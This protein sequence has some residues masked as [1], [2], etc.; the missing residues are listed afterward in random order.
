MR[1]ITAAQQGV[2]NTGRQAEY[3]R[4]SV[5]DSG[6][7]FRD[8]TTYPGFNAVKSVKWSEQIDQPHATFDI[9]LFRELYSLSL[10]PYVQGSALNR[11][12]NPANAFAALLAV[13]RELKIEVAIVAMDTP[14]GGSDWF[15][16]FH[17]RIETL[18][19]AN[20]FD[21]QMTGTSLGGRLSKQ[22]IKT[23]RVYSYAATAGVAVACRIWEAGQSYVTTDYLI[24]ASRGSSDSGFNKFLKCHV[25]GTSGTTE[26][27]WTTGAAQADNTTS[28]DY[29]G[30]PTVAG[31]PVEQIMQNILND[32]QGTGDPSVT[33]FT[34]SSPGWNITQFIQQREF[35]LD[36]IVALATQI[37]WDV[38][39]KWRSGTSQFEL[40]FY[41]PTRSSPTVNQTFGPSDY[42]APTQ[43]KVDINSIRNSV[44]V[45]Y[46]DASD[47]WP[48]GTPKRKVVEVTD[49]G[50][51]TKYGEMWME[52][53]E[54]QTSQIDTGAEATAFANAALSDCKDPTAELDIPIVHGFPWV[55]LNDYYTF[56]ANGLQFDTDQSLAVTQYSHDF[57]DGKMKTSFQTRGLPTIGATTYLRMSVHPGLQGKFFPH[58][59]VHFN[60]PLTPAV[61]LSN[62]V[63]GQR[64]TL[65][66]SF[67]K[68]Q[69]AEEY[70]HHVYLS[71]GATLDNTTL[72]AITPSRVLDAADLITARTYYH[73][74]VPR[75]RNGN[76]LIRMQPSVES[77]I[78]PFRAL[79]SHIQDGIA[80]GRYPLNGGFETRQD[81]TLPPD[82]WTMTGGV[83]GTNADIMND[84]SGIS[85]SNYI[86][87]VRANAGG[88]TA[89][90][91]S[92]TI[93]IVGDQIIGGTS[94]HTQLYR[95]SLWC[96]CDAANAT[97]GICSIWAQGIDYTGAGSSGSK[98]NIDIN[99]NANSGRWQFFEAYF[100]F[101]ADANTRGLYIV[102]NGPTASA[103]G[104][105]NK[106][107]FD[108]LRL[109][110]VGTPWY[111]VN[112]TTQLTD[113]NEALP[114]F[115]NSYANYDA[116]NEPT[117]AFRR[118]QY[119]R[120]YARGLVAN[121]TTTFVNKIIFTLP[122]SF[123]PVRRWHWATT[124][125]GKFGQL[126]VATTGDVVLTIAD[127]ANPSTY[128]SLAPIQFDIH[129]T[130]A[131]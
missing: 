89:V 67:D 117:A 35:S 103:S 40:T 125:A 22:Y 108:E 27:I 88:T 34:P 131:P 36:A 30:A 111:G 33:L 90:L 115:Q 16:V 23:E 28:W 5:K 32:N 85:G 119:G 80:F 17:G 60:G 64:I 77:V 68:V 54:D 61:S 37:G 73:K 99:Y 38:R 58:K 8:L 25:N 79:S 75:F 49:S 47:L 65:A 127:S 93:P 10:S 113:A 123:A 2:L 121:A 20:G 50:S 112:N 118:N 69:T 98:G 114:A 124:A 1:T 42:L 7:T 107:Y 116:A 126:E 48:D 57:S 96:K 13:N 66:Q 44:R 84:G 56:S 76:R 129:D 3:C 4:V 62:V 63:G 95:L 19:P 102:I 21:I 55:E 94:R 106:W 78:T 109:E 81:N 18:D 82:W 128:I 105:G 70:E 43:L 101:D 71:S 87:V 51:I 72:K 91:R 104:A 24:P 97:A 110:H 52:I 92:A 31:N 15:E 46:G 53:Q 39:Y 9:E 45:I 12:F 100:N 86:K 41:L 120:V 74:V 122:A 130:L 11:G 59:L 83:W 6:G 29:I 26:P 14:P